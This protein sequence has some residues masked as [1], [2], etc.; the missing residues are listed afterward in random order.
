MVLCNAGM[1]H[2]AALLVVNRCRLHFSTNSNFSGDEF[3]EIE[4][5]IT[6]ELK[7]LL[8]EFQVTL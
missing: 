2:T 1:N 3:R 4:A 7:I 8:W 6:A 5:T